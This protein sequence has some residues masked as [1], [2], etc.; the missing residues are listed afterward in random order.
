MDQ[1]LLAPLA[2]R[3]SRLDEPRDRPTQR[4]VHRG[5][6]ATKR[7]PAAQPSAAARRARR[8][9]AFEHIDDESIARERR[10]IPDA[11]TDIQD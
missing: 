8:A 5:R 4:G 1:R 10:Y 2:G 9:D 11:H 3:L 7:R 6:R